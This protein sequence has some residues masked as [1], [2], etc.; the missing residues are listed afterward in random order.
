MEKFIRLNGK[1]LSL[2]SDYVTN[3]FNHIAEYMVGVPFYF[4]KYKNFEIIKKKKNSIKYIHR[5]FVI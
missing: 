1:I 5:L 2:G 4:N 3:P